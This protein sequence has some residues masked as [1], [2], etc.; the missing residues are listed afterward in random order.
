MRYFGEPHVHVGGK[1]TASKS[2]PGHPAI[3]HQYFDAS[4]KRVS[5]EEWH[6]DQTCAEIPPM[7][8]VLYQELIPP[9][10]GGDTMFLSAYKAYEELSAGM[11]TYLEGKTATHDG[12]RVFDQSQTSIRSRSIRSSSAIPKAAAS[13]F[14]S[15]AT[16]PAHI[17]DAAAARAAAFWH[18]LYRHLARPHWSMRF[19]WT[20][21][22]S[23]SGTI[24][25]PS[26]TRSGIIGRT[27]ARAIGCSS[28]APSGRLR[29]DGA[30]FLGSAV[31]QRRKLRRDDLLV[32][33]RAC[34]GA[35]PPR[36]F[37]HAGNKI[38]RRAAS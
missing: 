30:A 15:T 37:R 20:L 36:K 16:S 29:P 13:C 10:G 22:R 2:V 4:S 26:I 3:R 28:R 18:F 25:A 31:P 27:C 1:G 6:S 34:R 35:L 8:S 23:R 11:K 21:I 9:N 5:G 32:G 24:A 7:Y 17:N 38:R 12:A 14:T 19:R 33:R